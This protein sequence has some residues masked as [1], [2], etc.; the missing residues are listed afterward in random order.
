LSYSPCLKK[1]NVRIADGSFC[2]VAGTSSIACT[3]N[4]QLSSVL[5]ILSFPISLLSV[6]YLTKTLDCKIKFFPTHCVFQDLNTGKV[7][8]SGRQ[9]DGF[10]L[11]EDSGHITSIDTNRA[12]SSKSLDANE[13]IIQWHRRLG[14]PSFFVLER[15]F[16]SLF[17]QSQPNTFVSDAF[18]FAK[19]TRHSYSSSNNK[20]SMPFM[21]IHSNAW[22]PT[23][24]VSLSGHRWFVTFIDCCTRRTWVYLTKTKSEVFSYFQ[25]FQKMICTQFDAKVKILRTDNGTEYME[26]GFRAYLDSHGILH[27]TSCVYTGEQNGVVER[28][29]RHLLE[30]TRSLLLTMN[31]PKPYGGDAVL[32]AAYLINRRPLKTLNFRAL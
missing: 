6:T 29:N 21:T 31:L 27:Q 2:S 9:Q 13:E 7:I 18:E 17:K 8:G 11:L 19:H 3:S 23:H 25:S 32:A 15:L 28:K 4:F 14:H 16:P 26:G 20:N 24:N 30:V 12:F 5:H 1:E 22:E 10:Y